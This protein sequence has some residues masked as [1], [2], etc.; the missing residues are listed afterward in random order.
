MQKTKSHEY[1]VEPV[2]HSNEVCL[3]VCVCGGGGGGLSFSIIVEGLAI[4]N[5]DLSF[6]QVGF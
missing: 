1:I 5:T 6:H 4:N 3:R 2:W